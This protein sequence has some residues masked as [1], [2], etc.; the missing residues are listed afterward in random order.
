MTGADG[1]RVFD[2]DPRTAAWAQA[3]LGEARKIA[4]DPKM[5]GPDNLRHGQTWFVGVDA[6]ASGHDGSIAGVPLAGP[7]KPFVAELP[8][9]KA[10][11]SI[12]YAGYPK[13]DADES[14]ANHRYRRTRAAAHVDGLLPMG[15]LRRRFALEYHAYILSLPLNDVTHSPTVVWRGSQQIMQAALR[16]AIG[17]G[18]VA[19]VDI[20]DAY[21][22]ARREVFETCEQVPLL[23]KPGQSAL[24]HPF[25]LHGTQAWGD[26]PDPTGEGRM[27]A[28]LRPEC[29]GGATEWL[30]TP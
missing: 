30:A 9:H 13:Q 6:L 10:Q 5:R 4:A 20:T 27:I 19:Q 17:E 8:Q 24:L 21:Q 15:K 7:W 14:D 1:F 25:V 2:H 16:R 3:A 18:P 28:F 12:I 23:L 29:A 26:D 22:A 11:L